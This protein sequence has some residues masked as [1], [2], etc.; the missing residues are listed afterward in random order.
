MS[1]R[2]IDRPIFVFGTGRSGTS[3]FFDLLAAHPDF[4]WFSNFTHVFPRVPVVAALSRI[5]D[6]PFSERLVSRR[7]RF[8]PKPTETYRILN[9]C[10]NSRFTENRLLTGEHVTDEARR[11]FR[12]MVRL[13]LALQGKPRFVH[14]HTGFARVGYL[15]SIFPDARFIHVYRDGRAVASSMALVDWWSG[16]LGSWWWGEMKPE[17]MEEY[18]RSDREPV[19]L[20]GIVWKTLMD[21][22]EEECRVLPREQYF[23]VRYDELTQEVGST[24]E[25]ARKF[26]GL[27]ENQKWQRV[28]SGVPVSN[29]DRKWERTLS[30]RQKGLLE[31][32]LGD[33][34]ERFGF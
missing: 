5:H 23:R 31:R 13:Y 24:F 12:R 28:V 1:D 6:L 20:A 34:L 15:R 22:I 29:M 18:L 8:V 21:L 14:K 9:H 19:V 25:R 4:A 17:Y 16:D 30:D 11:R 7:T 10:T 3:L 32:C 2:P 27:P 33:H 26:C